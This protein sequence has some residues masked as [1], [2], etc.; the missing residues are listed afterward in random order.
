MYATREKLDIN[1]NYNSVKPN[2]YK[3]KF[4]TNSNLGYT[5]VINI[6]ITLKHYLKTIPTVLHIIYI[7]A[8]QFMYVINHLSLKLYRIY[9]IN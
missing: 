2:I 9:K 4:I 5:I 1:Q 6:K 7:I 8:I 3:L